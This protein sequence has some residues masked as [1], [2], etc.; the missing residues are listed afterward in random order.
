MAGLSNI[1]AIGLPPIDVR[2]V[3]IP[4]FFSRPSPKFLFTS[5]EKVIPF[6]SWLLS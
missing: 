4:R 2:M 5:V 3:G 6:T 1:H